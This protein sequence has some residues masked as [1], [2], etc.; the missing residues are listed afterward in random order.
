MEKS[1][2]LLSTAYFPPVSY[3]SGILTA[4]SLVLEKHEY[5][6][7]QTYRNRCTLLGA[8]G[9]VHLVIPVEKGRSGKKPV[10]DIR[11]FNTL[12]WQ[13]N[14]WRTIFSAYNSSPFFEFYKDDIRPFYENKF[15]FLLDFNHALLKWVLEILEIP[16]EI[17]Y[18]ETYCKRPVG[19]SDLRSAVIPGPH[20]EGTFVPYTQ[21]FSNKYGFTP[22]LSILDL[23]FNKGPESMRIL[24]NRH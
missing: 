20:P 15:T 4:S 6:I 17:S 5:F 9:P 21:V 12:P 24:Q 7:K 1:P 11:I 18:T 22:N 16:G 3:I 13:R 14:H 23:L 2:V 8:N 10:R 19:I